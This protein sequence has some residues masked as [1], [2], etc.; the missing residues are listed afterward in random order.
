MDRSSEKFLES[1]IISINPTEPFLYIVRS[2]L[3]IPLFLSSILACISSI[4]PFS[5]SI[6]ACFLSISLCAFV[7]SVLRLTILVL[8]CSISLTISPFSASA[9]FCFSF[10]LFSSDFLSVAYMLPVYARL[11]LKAI[12]SDNDNAI[13]LFF[14]INNLQ[15]LYFVS[16]NLRIETMLPHAPM[17]TPIARNIKIR[18][19]DRYPA[20]TSGELMIVIN[21]LPTSDMI[22]R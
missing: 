1:R 8:Y 16:R 5:S 14:L 13:T 10:M 3:D 7:I 17:L 21:C 6:S 4:F 20:G 11:R 18:L 15:I 12:I 9:A 22:S 2:L 19:T